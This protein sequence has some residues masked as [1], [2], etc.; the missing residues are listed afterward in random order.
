MTRRAKAAYASLAAALFASPAWAAS[1]S[2]LAYLDGVLG[3][4]ADKIVNPLIRAIFAAAM[5]MFFWGV[6]QFIRG[7]GDESARSIGKQHMIWGIVG[8]A[9]MVSAFTVIQIA[10]GQIGVTPD[11]TF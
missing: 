4:I 3:K 2:G 9:I 5:I 1:G 10:T 11:F 7:A 6:L 8:M